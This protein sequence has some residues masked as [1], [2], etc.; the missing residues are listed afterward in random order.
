MA[1]IFGV[2]ARAACRNYGVDDRM[3]QDVLAIILWRIF[4]GRSVKGDK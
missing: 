3:P 2:A 1:S 4:V